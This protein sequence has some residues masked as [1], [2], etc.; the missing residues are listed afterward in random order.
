PCGSFPT[1]PHSPCQWPPDGA[2]NSPERRAEDDARC[3]VASVQPIADGAAGG[4]PDHACGD[5]SHVRRENDG[6]GNADGDGREDPEDFPTVLPV[7]LE[8]P[9]EQPPEEAEKVPARIDEVDGVVEDVAVAVERL[10]VGRRRNKR[11]RSEEHTS[12]L[13]SR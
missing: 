9:L 8:D 13:Q 5:G 7:E 1:P 12:E 4:A 6:N 2:S 10:R 3:R 11:V